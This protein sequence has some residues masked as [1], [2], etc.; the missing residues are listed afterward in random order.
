MIPEPETRVLSV[1]VAG[2]PAA[3]G[4]KKHIGG[5]RMVEQS[6]YVKPWREQIVSAFLEQPYAVRKMWP[7]LGEVHVRL[8]FVMPRPVSTPRRSTPP[9]VK[10]PDLDKLARAA[11]DAITTSQAWKD[12]SQATR[13]V[14]TKRIA[15][16]GESPG[17]RID[18]VPVAAESG[19]AA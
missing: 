3:Q 12:D 2:R 9:A 14:A 19:V 4:S 6:K 15:G 7:I 5:G 8:T 18:I 16:I 11:F 1:W 10:K 13:L 17:V